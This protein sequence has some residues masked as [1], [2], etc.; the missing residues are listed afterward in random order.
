MSAAPLRRTLTLLLAA[1]LSAAAAQ[2]GT[3]FR[4]G[5]SVSGDHLAPLTITLNAAA[6]AGHSVT[7]TFGDGGTSTGEQVA[8]TYYRPGTYQIQVSL[9]DSQGRTVSRTEISMSVRSS[10]AEHADLTVLH[11]ADGT[12]RL[13]GLGSVLYR[14]GP[15]RLLLNGREVT[16]PQ[17]LNSG[18]N[19]VTAQGTTS[20]GQTVQRQL[21]LTAAALTA[22][23]AF[24]SEV[25]RL[26]NQARAQ[27]WNCDAKRPGG[28]ALPPLKGNP[29]LDLAAQAQSSGMALYGYFDHTSALDG[30]SPMRRVQAAGLNPGSVAENIAAG[31]QT[32]KEVVDAWLRSPGHCRN[33]M[34]D[35]TLVG[36][37]YV[38]RPGTKFTRYWTQVFARP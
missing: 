10:G 4:V 7:W 31:Q 5:Y 13:S 9:L 8:Y 37:S 38:N 36:L 24:D 21:T 15:V 32:P 33:I 22:S 16:G 14:P 18:S 26:T 2:S 1:A 28:P 11:A 25:L 6:P 20:A 29:T 23:P 17:R 3:L 34:G 19:T 30:S 35:F 12:V 27:G